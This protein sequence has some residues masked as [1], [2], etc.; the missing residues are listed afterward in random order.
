MF[1]LV[2]CFDN[3]YVDKILERALLTED[4][5]TEKKQMDR[6]FKCILDYCFT[7]QQV[8]FPALLHLGG[9]IHSQICDFAERKLERNGLMLCPV[10]TRDAD[11][12]WHEQ[13]D[14]GDD[15]SELTVPTTLTC[16]IESK[17]V[18]VRARRLGGFLL[19][20]GQFSE[21]FSLLRDMLSSTKSADLRSLNFRLDFSEFYADMSVPQ[22]L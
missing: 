4:S 5:E 14:A 11:H 13:E 10:D 12:D 6:V 17:A 7:Q 3:S 20:S 2:D 9:L 22:V 19:T 21:S 16:K 18:E 8:P 15:E 1:H